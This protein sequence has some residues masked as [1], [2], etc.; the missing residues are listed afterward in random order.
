MRLNKR[1]QNG[2]TNQRCLKTALCS[3]S[4]MNHCNFMMALRNTWCSLFFYHHTDLVLDSF[5]CEKM[6]GK[7]IDKVLWEAADALKYLSR[8]LQRDLISHYLFKLCKCLVTHIPYLKCF[9][10]KT[11]LHQT[12]WR[13]DAKYSG[14][15]CKPCLGTMLCLNQVLICAPSKRKKYYWDYRAQRMSTIQ[16]L[17]PDIDWSDEDRV[18]V[19]Y[20]PFRSRGKLCPTHF[21]PKIQLWH[22]PRRIHKMIR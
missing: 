20:S 4:L 2:L 17:R 12:F 21:C 1:I 10:E 16:N 19:L 22:L 11:V 6:R 18:N 7:L 9:W 3:L 5:R 15:L 8:V 14:T 13:Q